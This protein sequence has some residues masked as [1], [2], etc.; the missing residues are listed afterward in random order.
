MSACMFRCLPLSVAQRSHSE[1]TVSQNWSDLVT[2]GATLAARRVQNQIQG[3]IDDVHSP[4]TS[5]S[6]LPHRLSAGV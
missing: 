4:H 1:Q 5:L 2:E 6:R 3:G